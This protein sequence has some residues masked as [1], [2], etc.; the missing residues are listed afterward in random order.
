MMHELYSDC[1]QAQRMIAHDILQDAVHGRE[2]SAEIPPWISDVVKMP[3][4][5][6]QAPS[7]HR[8]AA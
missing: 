8:P 6:G 5:N 2:I 1:E 4:V 3:F 7:E